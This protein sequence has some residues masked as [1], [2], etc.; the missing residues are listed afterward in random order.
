MGAGASTGVGAHPELA[1]AEGERELLGIPRA[2]LRKLWAGFRCFVPA[3]E[4]AVTLARF[5]EVLGT[6][7][8]FPVWGIRWRTGADAVVGTDAGAPQFEA[9]LY[10]WM[11]APTGYGQIDVGEWPRLTLSFP[12]FVRGCYL[13]CARRHTALLSLP[14]HRPPPRPHPG[15]LTRPRML[16]F[17]VAL[18]GGSG[19]GAMGACVAPRRPPRPALR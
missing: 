17:T 8:V 11:A 6:P 19:D 9:R 12:S 14:P 15:T 16:H 2:R 4:S 18:Y 7:H 1:E 5:Q 3:P 13:Y 10:A